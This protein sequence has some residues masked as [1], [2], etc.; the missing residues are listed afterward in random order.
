[1][2]LSDVWCLLTCQSYWYGDQNT[3]NTI[4]ETNG[5]RKTRDG[6][7]GRPGA[8]LEI[9]YFTDGFAVCNILQHYFGSGEGDKWPGSIPKNTSICRTI[10]VWLKISGTPL[11]FIEITFIKLWHFEEIQRNAW[12]LEH[13]ETHQMIGWEGLFVSLRIIPLHIVNG[14][15]ETMREMHLSTFLREFPHVSALL[16]QAL[17]RTTQKSCRYL[18]GTSKGLQESFGAFSSA[19]IWAF[20]VH[21]PQNSCLFL[22]KL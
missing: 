21:F 17:L 16:V 19:Y 9:S 15:L 6:S 12:Y 8:L 18:F 7:S 22:S 10:W 11:I 20:P 3:W 5:Q 14:H 1:M 13:A 4:P 2:A